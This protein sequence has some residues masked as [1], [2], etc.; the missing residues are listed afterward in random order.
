MYVYTQP[1]PQQGHYS[2]EKPSHVAKITVA[3]LT[4]FGR[5]LMIWNPLGVVH[6]AFYLA[7][8]QAQDQHY[9]LTYRHGVHGQQCQEL[10][11]IHDAWK[12][13][14][15][16]IQPAPG[17]DLPSIPGVSAYLRVMLSPD[18]ARTL[19][20]EIG[21]SVEEARL[22]GTIFWRCMIEAYQNHMSRPRQ[23]SAIAAASGKEPT[24]E[25]PEVGFDNLAA[26]VCN[27]TK[28]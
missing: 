19:L 6:G 2:P 18:G 22:T 8:T 14:V 12:P 1:S 7:Q 21:V 10:R 20:H 27:A 13:F 15:K 9:K 3:G 28:Q 16:E 25:L 5:P 11:L 24:E 26:L 23:Q 4:V 17:A